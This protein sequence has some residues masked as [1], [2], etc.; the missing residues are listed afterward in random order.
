MEGKVEEKPNPLSIVMENFSRLVLGIKNLSITW[1]RM[2]GTTLPGFMPKT[3]L[4]G[5]SGDADMNAPGLGFV[6]GVQ[7]KNFAQKA[8]ANHWLTNDQAINTPMM[9][10]YNERLTVRSTV[11]PIQGFRIELTANRSITKNKNSYYTPGNLNQPGVFTN[12]QETGNFSMSFVA[13]GSAFKKLKQSDNYYSPVFETFKNNRAI[14][15]SRLGKKREALDPNYDP[16]IPNPDGGVTGYGNTSQD[17]LIPA[18]MAAYGGINPGKVTLDKFPAIWNMMPNWRINYDGLSK[19]QLIQNFAKTVTLSHSY[20][21]TYNVGNY[22]SNE[23]YD[24]LQSYLSAVRDMQNNFIPRYNISSVSINEQFGPLVGVDIM[25][26]NSISTKLE[27]RKSRNILLS[28]GNNQL[29]ETSSDE[30]VAGAGYK[31]SDFQFFVKD[32]A[33][34]KKSYKSDLNLRA[35]VSI[36]DNKTI[37]RRLTNEPDQPAQG[38]K[39]VTIKFSADYLISDKFTMRMFYDRIVNTP[40]VALSYPTANTNFGF[41]LRF[42]LA[43]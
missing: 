9:L 43:Q 41:S 32:L 38:Q 19:I 10:T 2:Q 29:T 6:F 17:V 26:V 34:G 13:I 11:E 33:G 42:S 14:I 39:V 25:F 24:D 7:D 15:A 27:V 30:F 36:R 31:I 16:N 18:F 1:S 37:L 40:L 22:I 4:L 12:Q 28:L 21:A 8:I 5:M 3:K 35:D 20:T 23:I